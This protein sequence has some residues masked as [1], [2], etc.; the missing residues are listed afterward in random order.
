MSKF[1]VQLIIDL[2]QSGLGTPEVA[3]RIGCSSSNIQY[4]LERN[5]VELRK[6]KRIDWP[7]EEMRKW[8]EQDRMTVEEI[9]QRLGQASKLVNKVCK[10]HGFQMRPRGQKFG[11]EHKGWK[12]GRTV[13]KAGYI[14]VYRPD[15]PNANV[16]GYIREHRLV[17][18]EKLGRLLEKHEVVHHIDNST[19]NNHPDNLELFESNGRHLAETLRGKCP[20][21]SPEGRAVLAE[22]V[23]RAGAVSAS[24]RRKAKDADQSP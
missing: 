10:R 7:V 22:V 4:I 24:R 16:S 15:H 18:E 2:Y 20:N 23:K 19:D 8:Y 14:L 3:R 6:Q 13:D 1:D 21:W 11:P 17:M 5:G 12:G 9:G